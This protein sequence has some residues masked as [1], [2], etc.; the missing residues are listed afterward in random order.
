MPDTPPTCLIIGERSALRRCF[1]R[2]GWAMARGGRLPGAAKDGRVIDYEGVGIFQTIREA[3]DRAVR[4]SAGTQ[5]DTL[6]LLPI[7]GR[8]GVWFQRA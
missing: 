4:E 2:S 5:R 8:L 7:A 6:H 1:Q 3:G